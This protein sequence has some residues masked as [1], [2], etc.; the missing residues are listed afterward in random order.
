V[1]NRQGQGV[2]TSA[3]EESIESGAAGETFPLDLYFIARLRSRKMFFLIILIANLMDEREDGERN[4][5]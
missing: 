3:G 4:V 2:D 1:R 5:T